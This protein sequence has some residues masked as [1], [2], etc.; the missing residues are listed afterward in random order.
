MIKTE[1][2][3]VEILGGVEHVMADLM[4]VVRACL[5]YTSNIYGEELAES[6]VR[7]S[8][9]CTLKPNEEMRKELQEEVKIM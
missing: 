1:N 2:G 7:D 6:M 8:I 4:V 5:E 3:V 9:E